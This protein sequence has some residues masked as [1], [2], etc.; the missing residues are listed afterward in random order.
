[1]TLD[2]RRVALVTG[3]SRGIGRAVSVGLAG[4]A[5]DVAIQY[6]RNQR[7]AEETAGMVEALGARAWVLQSDFSVSGATDHLIPKVLAS[8]GRLDTLV[9]NAAELWHGEPP[10]ISESELSAIFAVNCIA[11]YRL[12][13]S[14][15][16][17]LSSGGRIINIS[18][19]AA[20]LPRSM[21]AAYA[22]S[23]AALESLTLSFGEWLGRRGITV[24]AIAPGPVRTELMEPWLRDKQIVASLARTSAH[25]RIASTDDIVPIVLFLARAES[26][27]INGQTIEATGGRVAAW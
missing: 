4:N 8:A 20:R 1:M 5:Y 6:R 11:V 18:S 17:V 7:A 19:D 26:A 9:N 14:A 25:G 10:H 13:A 21:V 15:A 23:K 24:N 12:M 3:A 27:W 16:E 2:S 22:A